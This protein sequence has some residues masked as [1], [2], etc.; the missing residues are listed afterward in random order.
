MFL[1]LSAQEVVDQIVAVVDEEVILKSELEFQ[2]AMFASQRNLDP[3][4]PK[5]KEELLNKLIE[6]KLL[7]AQAVLDTIE[8]SDDDVNNQLDQ[9]IAYYT[10]PIWLKR[11]T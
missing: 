8:V 6:D 2:V 9:V 3:T 10:Q 7:Y 1:I 11:K 5:I 4:D